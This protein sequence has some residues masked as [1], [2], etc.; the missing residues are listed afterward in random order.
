MGQNLVRSH[1]VDSLDLAR[2]GDPWLSRL[3]APKEKHV[4]DGCPIRQSEGCAP[5]VFDPLRNR[6]TGLLEYLTTNSGFENTF[7]FI[8]RFH[9]AAGKPQ[10]SGGVL[11]SGAPGNHQELVVAKNSTLR[12]HN[13]SHGN[14]CGQHSIWESG[15]C[16]P[17]HSI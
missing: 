7:G 6:N 12:V 4:D 8:P 13:E 17:R 5:H 15:F 10:Y 14:T 1:P 11:D 3:V 2:I 9:F 16:T